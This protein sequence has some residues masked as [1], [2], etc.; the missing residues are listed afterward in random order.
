[1]GQKTMYGC[2]STSFTLFTCENLVHL[3]KSCF[4]CKKNFVSPAKNLVHLQ[5]FSS[6]AISPE[7]RETNL[8]TGPAMAPII[9]GIVDHLGATQV[10]GGGPIELNNG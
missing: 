4:T 10:A 6:S 2:G 8:C 1:M 5:K 9:P 3:Q 7:Y